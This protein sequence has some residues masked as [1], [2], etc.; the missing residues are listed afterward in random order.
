MFKLDTRMDM[1]VEKF[2]HWWGSELAFLV[3]LRVRQ[4][5]GGGRTR[6]MLRRNDGLFSASY[7]T[8][9]GITELG[10]WGVDDIGPSLRESLFAANP[11]LDEAEL[12]LSLDARQALIKTFKLPSVAEE[13][14]RQVVAFE[15]DRLT[16]FKASQ[17]YY[18]VRVL[19]RL[20]D[21]KQIRVELALAPRQKL[22]VILDELA[23]LGWRPTRVDIDERGHD[24]LPEQFRPPV[25]QLP[26]TLTIAASVLLFLLAISVIGL[27]IIKNRSLLAELQQHVKT[28][29]KVAQE[30]QDLR[31]NAE[32]L[33]N[34]NGFLL[35]KKHQE[36]IM[37][38]MLEEL[39]KVIPDQTSL[40]GLQYRDRKIVIQGQS[41]AASTL[42]ELMEASPYFKNTSFVSPVTKDVSNGQ[43]RF[44]I[45]SEVVNGRFSDKPAE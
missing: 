11:E 32:K 21:T 3:P 1:D 15:L 39:T 13:N 40:N 31:E 26:R 29:N 10:R 36:P 43:E 35:H 7:I 23:A 44:Q 41:P 24:L 22:D 16:P 17:V 12:L 28:V 33:T 6:L 4:L 38:D 14:L 9:E 5:L 34:E 25:D 8:E 42:I 37:A 18:D 27:P 30:V 20:S 2:L 19:E 45:A